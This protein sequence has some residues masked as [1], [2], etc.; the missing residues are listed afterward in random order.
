[1]WSIGHRYSGSS[2]RNGNAYHM[3]IHSPTGTRSAQ[4]AGWNGSS[5]VSADM[6]RSVRVAGYVTYGHVYK[7]YHTMSTAHGHYLTSMS[8]GGGDDGHN[9]A[10]TT[11]SFKWKIRTTSI[12]VCL[13]TSGHLQSCRPKLIFSA[14]TFYP[15]CSQVVF[16]PKP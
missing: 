15:G 10:C 9:T 1:M 2:V 11:G 7:T 16:A 4:A 8:R 6:F 12:R 3:I 13:K 5:Y 14:A